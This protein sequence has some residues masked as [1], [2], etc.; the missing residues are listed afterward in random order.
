MFQGHTATH[1][2]TA[3]L[4]SMAEGAGARVSRELVR[5]FTSNATCDYPGWDP[6]SINELRYFIKSAPE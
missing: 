6:K 4:A 5:H 1:L 2:A 3:L